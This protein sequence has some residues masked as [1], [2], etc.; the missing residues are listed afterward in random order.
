LTVRPQVFDRDFL[1]DRSVKS[2]QSLEKGSGMP[3][4]GA[5]R[6]RRRSLIDAAI[7]TIGEQGTLDVS[8]REI[9]HRAGMST[10]L[11]FH[12]FGGKDEIIIATMRHLLSDFGLEVRAGLASASSPTQ[13][14][15]A[16]VRASFAASQFERTTIA[17]WLVFYLHAYSS[18]PARRLLEVYT[19]RLRSNLLDALRQLM[20]G[21]HALSAAE[22]IA[23]MIDGLYVRHALRTEGPDA[24]AAVQLCMDC[25]NDR[26][27]RKGK[28][29]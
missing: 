22:A 10:A 19:R 21:P 27:A 15:E 1:I 25:F 17:A 26:L 18:K 6:E 3:R 5:Q 23:A 2:R 4:V 13:R 8:V 28:T 14:I 12:Y 11:A 7:L 29:A 16:I 20:P 9:A 24:A